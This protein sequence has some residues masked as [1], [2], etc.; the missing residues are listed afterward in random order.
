MQPEVAGFVVVTRP[1]TTWARIEDAPLV[2]GCRERSTAAGAALD[3][4]SGSSKS[5]QA[6]T[7]R[8]YAFEP[9]RVLNGRG[10]RPDTRFSCAFSGNTSIMPR[11][12]WSGAIT[13]GLV[14]VPVRMY[15]A[16]SEHKLHFHWVHEKDESP[17]GY[18]K[19]CK[20]EEKPVPDDEV[21]KA[22]EFEP[23]E[24]VFME[25]EDF[26][27][28]RA[29]GYKTIDITD[30][31][32][33][34]QIDPIYFARTYY[35]GPQEGGEKV[36]SLLTRAMEESGL[37]AVA[38]FVMRDRQNLGCLRVRDGVITLEQLYFADEIR[39]LD[40][41][42]PST[43]KVAKQEL[44]MAQQ[45]IDNFAGDFHPDKYEDTYRDALCEIIKA[46]RKGKQV[47]HAPETEEAAPPDLLEALRASIAAAGK[48]SRRPAKGSSR[49]GSNGG[50]S[51]LSKAELEQRAKQANIAGRSK[52]SKDELIEALTEAA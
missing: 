8:R 28:A 1:L 23:G 48:G 37:A 18:Q 49:N 44:A 26:E 40:E 21:V 43:A 19:I 46:K 4:S 33:Y 47:H 36:Y 32:P 35:L 31:V 12:I 38:K 5:P 10:A 24:Y 16:I 6:S 3:T 42:K 41:I 52:M 9:I 13:F 51:D 2:Q 29:E 22:F 34:E 30:F 50:L 45:L 39:E 14:N 20:L 27:A 11:A 7:R 25:D 15:S 17:I